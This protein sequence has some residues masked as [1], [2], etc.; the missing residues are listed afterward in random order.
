MRRLFALIKKEFLAI[1]YDKK[2]LVVVIVPPLI[3]VLIFAFAATLEVKNIDLI[4]LDKDGSAQSKNLLQ[5]FQGSRYIRTLQI[6]KSYKEGEEAITTQKT[7]AFVIIPNE[8]AKKLTTS[9]AQIQIIFDGRRSNSAQIAEAYL[10]QII[11]N[12]QATILKKQPIQI[13]PRSFYNPNLDNFWWIVP[14]L[15]GSI[16]MVVAIIL[17]SL[18]IARERE[19][20]TFEQILVS[21]LSSLEILLGKLLPAVLIST[22]E[23]TIILFI[24]IYFFGV[25]LNGSVWL[26]YLSVVTFLFSMSGVGLFISAISKTQ[27][28][29]ILGAFVVLL[30][31][32]LLSGFATPVDNMPLWLQ[33]F[34]NFIP[35]KY[36][37]VL[38]KGVF[39]KDISFGIA[40]TQL[41]PMFLLGIISI[42]TTIFFF[43]KQTG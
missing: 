36:Y 15:F 14:N 7:L 20:G 19:L 21:P 39:L 30:P 12:F 27:Q 38:I 28:Q 11:L 22:F 13:I 33:P 43:K 29:A 25:P 18:S 5:D 24:A 41:L 16:T 8:F 34:T 40:I 31:S 23:S 32:F 10:N 17:T 37:L 1:K 6:A 2:S 35:L 4:V 42:V 9:E 26:L 3:Q